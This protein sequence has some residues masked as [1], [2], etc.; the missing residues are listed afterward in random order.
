MNRLCVIA[1]FYCLSIVFPATALDAKEIVRQAD[2][3]Y[4]GEKSSYSEM[5]MSI[6][7]PTYQRSLSF[8]SWAT[9]EGDAL[10]LIT[11]PAREKGQS[12][13][14]NGNNIWYWN[15]TIQRLIKLPPSMLSQGYMG[16]DFTIDDIL[17][18][19]SL[20]KD[21]THKLLKQEAITGATCHVIELTPLNNAAV[22]WGMI[23]LWI[24]VQ[25]GLMVKS[26]YYDEDGFLV[27]THVASEPKR[28]DGRL[29]PSVMDIIPAD[30]P[31]HKTR[32]T[33]LT[34]RFNEAYPASFFTQQ[35]MKRI[36]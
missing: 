13:L 3:R 30:E 22:V 6:I 25:D 24:T 14:K 7:R 17:K 36:K 26:E 18:E 33:L 32:I 16:S 23:K 20:V 2:A 27:K 19:S 34:I 5:S 35:T 21:Y 1:G 11:A 9:K 15:P 8:K 10:T 28:F 12:F 31:G 29:L 4:N